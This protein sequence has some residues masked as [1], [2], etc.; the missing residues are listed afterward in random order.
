VWKKEQ[1]AEGVKTAFGYDTKLIVRELAIGRHSFKFSEICSAV[2]LFFK[3]ILK[4]RT[5]NKISDQYQITFH[6][7]FKIW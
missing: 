5:V 7:Y 4:I 6:N 1:K 2:E 3:H